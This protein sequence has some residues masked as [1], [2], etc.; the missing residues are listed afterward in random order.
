MSAPS[1]TEC[2]CSP[3]E[4]KASG[5]APRELLT[6]REIAAKYETTLETIYGRR[7]ELGEPV[8]R[9]GPHGAMRYDARVVAAAM[10]SK[11]IRV[12]RC[13]ATGITPQRLRQ[14]AQALEAAAAELRHAADVLE[15]PNGS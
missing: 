7:W 15:P 12:R 9:N 10:G 14:Q 4:I 2:R 3:H 5:T 8:D 11:P 13:L 1:T 6:V